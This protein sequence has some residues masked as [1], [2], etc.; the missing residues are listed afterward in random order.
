LGVAI[1][2]QKSS[3]LNRT[4]RQR[5]VSTND[6][7]AAYLMPLLAILAAGML[8]HALSAGF[9]L[10]YPLRLIC[11]AIVLWA[12]RHCYRDL[13]WRASWR[14]IAT[15]AL[16]F[17]V[18]AGFAHFFTTPTTIPAP[19]SLLPA[20]LRGA[21]IACRAAAAIITVPIA[22]EL[23]YRGYLLRRLA[24]AQFESITLRE[25]RRPA[26][27]VSSILFGITHGSLWLPGI[28]A[29]LTYG[30]LAMK[31]NR[32]GESVVAHATT[33]ALLAAYVLIFNQ[34]QLW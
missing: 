13:D 30:A 9:D 33:N 32:I 28:A 5:R 10:L 34:W 20:P 18:W 31:S 27:I 25:V 15:G 3:W 12:Y 23:A 4:A 11:G 24:K 16:L 17:C 22:E 2:A 7:T 19:L 1:L 26:L 29:G 21:W 14:G 8:A 6:A